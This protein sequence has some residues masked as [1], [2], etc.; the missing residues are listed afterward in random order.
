MN[1]SVAIIFMIMEVAPNSLQI[2]I[3]FK[4]SKQKSGLSN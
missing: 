4:H 3:Y 2:M 1:F